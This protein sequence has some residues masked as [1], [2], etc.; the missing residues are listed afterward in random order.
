MEKA[1]FSVRV[2]DRT[3]LVPIKQQLGVPPRLYSCHTAVIDGRVVEGHVPA[4]V[5][6]RY[7]AAGAPGQGL[8][9]PGMPPG[10][11]GMP[12]LNPQPYDVFTFD[13]A[14]IGVFASLR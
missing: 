12:S 9:V 4:D 5:I 10:S 11:P 6:Q 2:D 8:G 13:G 1:G 3:D 14:E 7:L